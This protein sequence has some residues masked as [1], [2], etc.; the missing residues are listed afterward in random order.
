LRWSDVDFADGFVEIRSEGRRKHR[1][2][3]SKSRFV[4]M[5][6]Q[7][8]AATKDYAA[9]TRLVRRR[10]ECALAAPNDELIRRDGCVRVAIA[11]S[12]RDA[13]HAQQRDATM[14][15]QGKMSTPSP[16]R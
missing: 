9:R 1:T 6:P 2:K 15:Q 8:L 10:T 7:L 14:Q 11:I 4:P 3:G 5:T 13:E 16:V 12:H